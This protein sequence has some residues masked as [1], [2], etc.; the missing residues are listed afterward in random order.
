LLREKAGRE[1]GFYK[2]KKYVRIAGHTAWTGVLLALDEYLASKNIRK[3][4]GRKGKEWYE[5]Q[6]SKQNKKII[7]AFISAYDGLHLS[8][9]YDGNLIVKAAQG[10]IDAGRKVLQLCERG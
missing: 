4:T 6:L 8:M 3:E 1:N 9:G 2:D 10:S 7:T 5:E